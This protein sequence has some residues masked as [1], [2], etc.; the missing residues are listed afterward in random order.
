MWHWVCRESWAR[1][2]LSSPVL[3]AGHPGSCLSLSVIVCFVCLD[4]LLSVLGY[5]IVCVMCAWVGGLA[6]KNFW[7]QTNRKAVPTQVLEDISPSHLV[8]DGPH[9]NA[10]SIPHIMFL[11]VTHTGHLCWLACCKCCVGLHFVHS[12]C[13]GCFNT[14]RKKNWKCARA[15]P[16]T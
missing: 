14:R 8:N 16:G 4:M 9:A 1:K 15:A 13:H 5:V 2:R 11:V 6:K 3:K 10:C 12:P 7:T